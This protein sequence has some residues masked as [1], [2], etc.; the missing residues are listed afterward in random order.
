MQLIKEI[1]LCF[2]VCDRLFHFSTFFA[3]RFQHFFHL[4]LLYSD[5]KSPISKIFD[6]RRDDSWGTFLLLHKKVHRCCFRFRNIMSIF[7]CLFPS[8]PKYLRFPSSGLRNICQTLPMTRMRSFFYLTAVSA[9]DK[10]FIKREKSISNCSCFVL[11]CSTISRA[12]GF[13]CGLVSRN[14]PGQV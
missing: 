11:Y 12:E 6:Q 10:D 3:Y 9:T 4:F 7:R 13:L 14:L 1:M 5:W 8:F 2:L